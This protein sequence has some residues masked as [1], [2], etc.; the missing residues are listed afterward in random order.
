MKHTWQD[1]RFQSHLSEYLRPSSRSARRSAAFM[2]PSLGP[3]TDLEEGMRL[4]S[5][6]S[7]LCPA[8]S[9]TQ[10]KELYNSSKDATNNASGTL[11]APLPRLAPNRSARTAAVFVLGYRLF[12]GLR[13]KNEPVQRRQRRKRLGLWFVRF[14]HPLFRDRL[15][16]AI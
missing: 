4:P 16:V 12:S 2:P 7:A 10:K 1:Q 3:T 14:P 5:S 9:A 8:R 6:Q 11:S 13:G 15:L